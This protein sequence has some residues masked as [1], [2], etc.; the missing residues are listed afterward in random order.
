MFQLLFERSADA[1]VLFDP[2][3]GAI[4]STGLTPERKEHLR[5]IAKNTHARRQNSRGKQ[6]RPGDDRNGAALH[7]LNF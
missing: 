4:I 2:Q 7:L 3:T 5:S 6:S 1:I